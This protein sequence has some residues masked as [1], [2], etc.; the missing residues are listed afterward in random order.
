MR[1]EPGAMGELGVRRQYIRATEADP[2]DI[3]NNNPARRQQGL[4]IRLA[5]VQIRRFQI[6]GQ[7]DRG[8]IDC[9]MPGRLGGESRHAD[10]KRTERGQQQQHQRRQHPGRTHHRYSDC[11]ARGVLSL[12]MSVAH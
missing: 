7:Q 8:G 11:G 10:Q 4:R 6:S 9:S 5:P 1:R 2:G 12:A 3:G